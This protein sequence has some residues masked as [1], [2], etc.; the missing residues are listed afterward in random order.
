MTV[1]TPWLADGRSARVP[2]QLSVVVG[3]GVDDARRDDAAGGVGDDRGAPRRSWPT[4]TMRPSRIPTSAMRPGAPVPSITVPPLMTSS[5]MSPP[6]EPAWPATFL[7][8]RQITRTGPPRHPVGSGPR[9]PAGPGGARRE[10]TMAIEF[11]HTTAWLTPPTS[12]QWRWRRGRRLRR[13][14]RLRP[15]PLPRPSSNRPIRT[16]PTA[17][18]A[19]A[20][21]TPWTDPWVAMAAMATVTE[22][23]RF[24]HNVFVFPL[25][26]PVEVA[27]LAS[28]AAAV[29]GGRVA[30]G[31]GRRV[32]EGGVRH[33]R[34]GLPHPWG[35]HRRG[36]RGLS[37]ALDRRAGEP[38][39]PLLLVPDRH[40]V[41]RR[42]RRH[43]ARAGSAA[44][45]SRRCGGRRATTAGSATAYPVEEAD[46]VL[47]RL[48]AAL[49]AEGRR[50]GT[51]GSRSSSAST[52]P[53]PPTSGASPS[54]ASPASWP[55]RRCSRA[56]AAGP[57][58]HG[59]R[60][61]A[62][63]RRLRRDRHRA[64]ERL[65]RPPR[66]LTPHLAEVGSGGA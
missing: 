9:R 26:H 34:R 46:A 59:R 47:D 43:R 37:Q 60:P 55:P 54:V 24:A 31:A 63:H 23:L 1:V 13:R 65:S 14:A 28:S 45:P 8:V 53:T 35:P 64:A 42:A 19:W 22:R 20:T 41:A 5:S 48:D 40:H 11:W 16:R 10:T 32:D 30:L 27:K 66:S 38:R 36:P 49:E 17:S 51:T 58:G 39:R 29:S 18:P 4:A 12:P 15:R 21:A 52:P 7:T 33:P 61:A 25:R 6:I 50:L 56:T 57:H 44:T 2:E 62:G 3:V